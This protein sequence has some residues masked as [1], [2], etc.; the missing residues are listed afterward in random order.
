MGRPTVELQLDPKHA[1]DLFAGGVFIAGCALR[2]TEECDLLLRGAAGEMRLGA[3]V[4]FVDPTGRGAGLEVVGFNPELRQKIANL[5]VPPAAPVGVV[6]TASAPV[7][8]IAIRPELDAEE[9]DV[10]VDVD[11][12]I[13]DVSSGSIPDY[14]EPLTSVD[15][16]SAAHLISELEV[17]TAGEQEPELK[18][19]PRFEVPEP[20]IVAKPEFFFDEA[21]PAD[22]LELAPEVI[23]D[24]S[25]GSA[26]DIPL[27][28]SLDNLQTYELA[29]DNDLPPP[30]KRARTAEP[31]RPWEAE[32]TQ[33]IALEELD[34]PDPEDSH[35]YH[36]ADAPVSD[37]EA[38]AEAGEADTAA[39]A[40]DD[41]AAADIERHAP[42]LHERMRGLTLVQQ[43]KYAHNGEMQE[44]I[45]L[46]RIYG[47]AVWEALLRNPRITGQEVARI[48]RMGAL[49]RP[50]IEQICGN[51]GWLQVPE[52]RRALLTHPRL[53]AD[54]VTR[55]LRL[56]PRHEL[57]LAMEQKVY[58]RTVREHAR[59]LLR[60]Y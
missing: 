7:A 60:G 17:E 11:V 48:A 59:R 2:V 20:V 9:P 16:P 51:G 45:L 49:P 37:G 36:L 19:H 1:R 4:V 50:L 44:R 38:E 40:A 39:A 43:L 23:R 18:T 22:D 26:L 29:T 54:Q 3:R 13:D 21:E 31:L 27:D 57:K 52:V 25:A 28:P 14:A 46:E 8:A 30:P 42:R 33:P 24:V 5:A 6:A 10:D 12:D 47:K 41:A 34:E 32:T 55:V 58:T 53:T 56:L 35:D 15:E